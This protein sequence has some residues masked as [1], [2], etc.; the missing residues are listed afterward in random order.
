M[1]KISMTTNLLKKLIHKV[2]VQE[3]GKYPCYQC[4]YKATEKGKLKQHRFLVHVS[5]K[6]A[7]NQCDYIATNKSNLKQHK[8]SIHESV[9]HWRKSNRDSLDDR[10]L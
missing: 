10:P 1:S 7:C 6:Y 2:I 8:L 4:D 9:K 3:H 5:A